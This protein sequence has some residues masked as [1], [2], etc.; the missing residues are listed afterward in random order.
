MIE[1]SNNNSRK[2]GRASIEIREERRK[3]R[4]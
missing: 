4:E 2:S 1:L 3:G